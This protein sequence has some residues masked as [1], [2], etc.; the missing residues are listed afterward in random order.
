MPG[1]TR[2]L[3]RLGVVRFV[4]ARFAGHDGAK[5][6]DDRYD[7]VVDELG[8]R[9][10]IEH[11]YTIMERGTSADEQLEIFESNNGKFEPVV[12]KL[13]ENTLENVPEEVF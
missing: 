4:G 10:E 1:T 6:K 13:I 11:I 12:D 7:E 2:G 3:K 9:K 8:S 5:E